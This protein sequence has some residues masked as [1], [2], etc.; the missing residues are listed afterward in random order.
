MSD[1]N[2]NEY[3][4]RLFSYEG[5]ELVTDNKMSTDSNGV[6][7]ISGKTIK[8]KSNGQIIGYAIHAVCK[9]DEDNIHISKRMA[10]PRSNSSLEDLKKEVDK[11][12]EAFNKPILSYEDYGV[13]NYAWTNWDE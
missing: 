2:I 4:Y 11:Y 10:Y 1:P 7:H 9:D 13:W 5:S 6:A 3:E 8:F 12:Q